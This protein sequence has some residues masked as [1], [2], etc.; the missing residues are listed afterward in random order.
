MNQSRLNQFEIRV[1]KWL[2]KNPAIAHFIK[3]KELHLLAFFG[4]LFGILVMRLFWL[5]VVSGPAYEKTLSNQHMSS[6]TLK[7]KR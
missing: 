1:N 3:T 5:Q 7:A 2:K 4:L 6:S